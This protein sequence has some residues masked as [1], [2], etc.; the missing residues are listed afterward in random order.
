MKS[1]RGST[2]P[3]RIA[4]IGGGIGG[5]TTALFLHHFCGGNNG[6]TVDI[7]EQATAFRELGAGI[8]LGVNAAKLLHTIGIGEAMNAISGTRGGVWFTLRRWDNS[9]EITTVSAN[10]DGKVRYAAVSRHEFLQLLLD[11]V[12]QRNAANLHTNK[13]CRDLEDLGDMVR[14]RFEDGTAVEA[15]LVIGCDGIHSAVRR[16]FIPDGKAVYSGKILY[17]AV[18]PVEKLPSPWPLPSHSVLWIGPDKHVVAYTISANQTLN[19]VGCVT[20]SED[21]IPD[22]KESWSSTCDID[23]MRAEFS[24][25]DELV[26]KI[27]DLLPPKPSKWRI[28]DRDP[29]ADWIF[30]DGKVALLG[31]AAHPMVPHQSAGAGQAVEDG[32]ILA[33]AL[34]EYLAR[35]GGEGEGSKLGPWM[36]LY[37]GVRLPRA[38]RVQETSREAG[39]LFHMQLPSMKGKTYDESLPLLIEGTNNRLKWI[40][41]EDLDVS[42]DNHKASILD[43]IEVV[44][45]TAPQRPTWRCVCM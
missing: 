16:Q 39:T 5:L 4:I 1:S 31:D 36:T 8:G 17:R 18:V 22:L 13:K 30:L 9:G 43:T 14:V 10:E 41:S 11:F 40:W 33:K 6:I 23:E 15:D 19:F 26:Q 34:A 32:Y 12:K 28:N 2:A 42:Y 37:Q 35:R 29:V 45:R 44:A 38:Q 24:D 25:C 20:K 27:I 7:Y 3:F 21:E